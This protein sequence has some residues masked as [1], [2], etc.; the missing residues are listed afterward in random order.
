MFTRPRHYQ[1][2]LQNS[3]TNGEEDARVLIPDCVVVVADAVLH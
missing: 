1:P 2:G 3:T